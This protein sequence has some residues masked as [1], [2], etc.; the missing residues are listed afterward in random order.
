MGGGFPGLP[1]GP[2]PPTPPAQWD[3]RIHEGADVLRRW[4]R[5]EFRAL[6]RGALMVDVPCV[7]T[8]SNRLTPA[9]P[10]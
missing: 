6:P 3:L 9:A 8:W 10:G 2:T 7:T 5:E 1:A 4:S